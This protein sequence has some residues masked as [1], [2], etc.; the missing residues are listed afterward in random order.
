MKL[1]TLLDAETTQ[2]HIKVFS[3]VSL[4]R[5][6]LQKGSMLKKLRQLTLTLTNISCENPALG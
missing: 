3:I 1:L 2:K 6:K 4:F 5:F